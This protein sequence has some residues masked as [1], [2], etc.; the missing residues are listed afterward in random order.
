MMVLVAAAGVGFVVSTTKAAQTP[1]VGH[2]VLV[3]I[4]RETSYQSERM[5]EIYADDDEYTSKDGEIQEP[6]EIECE[7]YRTLVYELREVLLYKN[8]EEEPEWLFGIVGSVG[9]V[10]AYERPF[11]RTRRPAQSRQFTQQEIEMLAQMIWGEARGTSRDEQKLTVWVALQRMD[12][13][14]RWGST[15]KDVI[16]QYMQFHGYQ[17]TFPILQEHM[18]VALEVL[19]SW[20]AGEAPKFLY[21]FATSLPYYYFWGDGTHNWFREHWN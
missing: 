18:D 9:Y 1:Q 7:L 13:P 20:V 2:Q 21:P 11:Q 4:N 19:E 12:N 15:I 10:S 3:V 8:A 17:D 16:S 6:Y 5:V 14:M